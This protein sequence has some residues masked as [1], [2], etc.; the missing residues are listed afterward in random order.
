MQAPPEPKH[1]PPDRLPIIWPPVGRLDR[2]MWPTLHQTT[3]KLP[4]L[5]GTPSK[6]S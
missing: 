1:T 3:Q 2:P 4:E 5:I 6:C